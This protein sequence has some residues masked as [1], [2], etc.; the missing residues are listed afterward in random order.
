[1][2]DARYNVVVSGS[3]LDGFDIEQV[4]EEFA[5]L[6]SLAE[7]KTEQIFKKGDVVIKRDVAEPTANKFIAALERIGAA[8]HLHPSPEEEQ[9]AV[10][11]LEPL[12]KDAP[13][14]PTG[15]ATQPLPTSKDPS[16]SAL[17]PPLTSNSTEPTESEQLSAVNSLQTGTADATQSYSE[18]DVHPF[19]FYGNGYEYFRIWIVNVLLTIATL[20]IYSAWAKVR[21]AQYFY[22]N[23]E[24]ADSRFG[25]HAKPL[26]I[27]KGRI[28]AVLAFVIYSAV[29]NIFPIAGLALTVL[30]VAFLPWIVIRS[31]RFSRRMSSW[32]NI[33]FGFD[34]TLWPAV[35]AFILWPLAGVLSLGLLMPLAMYKQTEFVINNTRYGTA[36]F[37]LEP[38]AKNYFII[39]AA[40]FGLMFGAGFVAWAASVVLPPAAILITAAAYFYLFVFVSV[41]TANLI[42]ENT[43]LRGGDFGFQS[44]WSDGSYLKLVLIN[45][46]CTLLTLG[47]FYPW[48]MVRIAHY[49]AEHLTLLA[50]TDLDGFVASEE[51]HV[52]AL[53]EEM[54]DIFDVDVGL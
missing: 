49:K 38:C 1:M 23:A 29:Q 42:Y 41:R 7:H 46:I 45:S 40:A 18:G 35:I 34:G 54:G 48:A 12:A 43:L 2:S 37:N 53:G 31:L 15:E 4:K 44:D 26:T 6:F 11:S 10:L 19:A 33:R 8:A 27:L 21:N 16:A 17:A 14:E 50:N 47:F 25:Y 13:S 9:P 52:T 36:S 28:I 30:F 32:R 20:G 39:Y 5:K 3:A 24:V 22:G 51:E